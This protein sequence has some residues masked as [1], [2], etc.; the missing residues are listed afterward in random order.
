MKTTPTNLWSYSQDEVYWDNDWFPT[1][2]E[3]IE[4]GREE[5]PGESFEIGQQYSLEFTEE[6][7]AWFDLAENAIEAMDDALQDEVGE[8]AEYWTNQ[9]TNE[10]QDDLNKRLAKTIMGWI[11][12]RVGQPNVF[13][14][15][16]MESVTEEETIDG[17]GAP[18][19][20]SP[21][22]LGY[23]DIKEDG[24]ELF[25]GDCAKCW[26]RPMED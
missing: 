23:T 12:D 20:I 6:Q 3:A 1:K 10:D 9:I 15:D 14:V 11:K 2:E 26:S 19:F 17:G 25:H 7:C 5:W 13:L 8:V 22:H 18:S 4:A 21:K 16:D 24:T